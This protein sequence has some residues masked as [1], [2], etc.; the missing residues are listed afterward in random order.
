MRKQLDTSILHPEKDLKHSIEPQYFEEFL[1]SKGSNKSMRDYYLEAS[2]KQ[3]DLTGKVINPWYAA[4][5]IRADYVDEVPVNKNYPRAQRLVKETILQA[6]SNGID[7][8]PFSK[9]GKI[10]LLIIVFAGMGLDRKLNIKYIR[11]HQGSLSEPIEVQNGI[12]ADKYC[13]VSELPKDD[14]GCFCHEVGHLLG[15]PDMYK[16]GYSP[17]VGEW[18][19]MG[20]GD[21]IDEGKTPAHPSAWCKV[22]LGWREPKILDNPPET[23][24]IPAIVDD[25]GTIY[26]IEV[27]GTDGKE[28]FL[29]ENRQHKGFDLKLPGSGLVIWHINEDQCVHMAPNSDPEH[30]FLTLVQSDGKSELQRDMNVLAKDFTGDDVMK[31][32]SGDEGDAYPGETHNRTFN[33]KSTPNS[34]SYE[35]NKS[36]VSIT[37]ISDS[38]DKM[39][40]QM[41]KKYQSDLIDSTKPT[42]SSQERLSIKMVQA[43]NALMLSE[44]DEDPLNVGYE[45]G[46]KDAVEKLKE[47]NGLNIYKEGYRE[48][49]HNGYE[50]A[51]KKFK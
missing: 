38:Q 40:A 46:K 14:L 32:L 19:L 51:R 50:M 45:D 7:F 6:K 18:C 12:W 10:D 22:H 11:P 42:D 29:L 44:K 15:L 9:N 31:E 13:L 35:G 16:E 8:T 2:W 33:E 5:G 28:Y 39:Q 37:S 49:Y 30:F 1:F 48:G 21:H 24:D 3:L 26:K 36:L 23:Y 34:D 47:K 20:I 27:K 17:I 25:D 4:H 43:F 41:G